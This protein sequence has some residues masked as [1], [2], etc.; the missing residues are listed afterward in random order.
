MVMQGKSE[1]EGQD[2]DGLVKQNLF[3]SFLFIAG[4]NDGKS[5]GIR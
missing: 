1:Q 4:A 5:V 3:D 2:E